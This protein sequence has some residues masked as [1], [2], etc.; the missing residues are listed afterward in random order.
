MNAMNSIPQR[1]F[2]ISRVRPQNELGTSTDIMTNNI[3]EGLSKLESELVLILL[4][5]DESEISSIKAAY[6]KYSETIH[7]LPRFFREGQSRVRFLFGS[8]FALIFDNKYKS[9]LNKES[10]LVNDR[11]LVIA[12]KVT[13]DEIVYGNILKRNHKNI[14]YYQYWSDPM[15][16]A[17]VLP[18]DL[19][20]DIKRKSL[21]LVERLAIKNANI[22]IYGT[23]VL[24]DV[25]KSIYPQYQEKMRYVDV[26]YN[27]EEREQVRQPVLNNEFK[28]IYA[29]NYYSRIRNIV[30]LLEAVSEL[31]GVKLDIYGS[32]D[33][34]KSYQN[35]N[36]MGRI[37]PSELETKICE[38]DCEICILNHSC[39][40][41]PGKLFYNM[42]HQIPIIVI[43]DGPYVD[44]IIRYIS[45][46]KRY[47]LSQNNKNSIVETINTVLQRNPRYDYDLLRTEYSCEKISLDIVKGGLE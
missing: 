7:L 8:L 37:S 40:Q 39:V 45:T 29:G 3:I 34:E 13:I 47:E 42:M 10:I 27:N 31:D 32:G 43:C 36:Y 5:D 24:M 33:I 26:A 6:S 41:I 14:I 15:A 19:K 1:I 18:V 2:F 9:I 44:D 25:Q 12:N 35:C 38:Y 23:R 16:V 17:G 22:V 21:A 30:P 28:L 4:Y 46:Y 11:D 20:R